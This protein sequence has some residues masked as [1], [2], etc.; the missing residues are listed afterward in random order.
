MSPKKEP[1][2]APEPTTMAVTSRAPSSTRRAGHGRG[3]SL[4]LAKMTSPL[5][6][7]LAALVVLTQAGC[8]V[9]LPAVGPEKEREAVGAVGALTRELIV[10]STLEIPIAWDTKDEQRLLERHRILK[11]LPAG[12]MI[13]VE[14]MT[15]RRLPYPGKVFYYQCR[16]IASGL[17]FDLDVALSD[18]IAFVPKQ[19]A[20]KAPEPT[21]LAVTSPAVAGAAPAS[22]VAHL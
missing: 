20:N 13:R 21:P 17:K 3:S 16:E 5:R 15:S 8:F 19:R 1:N 9:R 12:T 14:A 11:R 2:Q 22:G 10:I 18:A 6:L 7:F 4:T